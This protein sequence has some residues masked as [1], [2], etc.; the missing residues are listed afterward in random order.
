MSRWELYLAILRQQAEWTRSYI[1]LWISKNYQFG[2]WV[3]SIYENSG[4][5]WR[6]KFGDP[7]PT[8]LP[9]APSYC[10]VGLVTSSNSSSSSQRWNGHRHNVSLRHRSSVN[11][12]GG[13]TF[14]PKIYVWKIDEM[15][16][17]YMIFAW[18]IIKMP[19]FLLYLSE[20]LTKFPNFTW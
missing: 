16:A 10:T 19:K 7:N 11:F 18:K 6:T 15:P 5:F 1:V 8:C 3:S 9:L 12:G 20:T 13:T 17:F 4:R 14:C 2:S